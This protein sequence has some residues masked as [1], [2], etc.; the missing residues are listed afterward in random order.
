MLIA[1]SCRHGA[2]GSA[3]N[4]VRSVHGSVLSWA[5][6]RHHALM[7]PPHI[8][9][10]SPR[11]P[12]GPVFVLGRCGVLPDRRHQNARYRRPCISSQACCAWRD[13]SKPFW[14][15]AVHTVRRPHH[16][17]IGGSSCRRSLAWDG[18]PTPG[19]PH[20]QRRRYRRTGIQRCR[21][22]KTQEAK[23]D[24]NPRGIRK[25]GKAAQAQTKAC[26]IPRRTS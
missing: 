22:R 10:D 5:K 9:R 24:H 26:Q 14:L 16:V 17:R 25:E 21:R 15:S 1:V 18:Q 3:L 19:E 11:S 4:I 20:G 8:H 6:D 23:E 2:G 13:A 7:R 12:L